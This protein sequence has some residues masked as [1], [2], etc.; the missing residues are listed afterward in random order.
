MNI[1]EYAVIGCAANLMTP[2]ELHV[3]RELAALADAGDKDAYAAVK[4]M[5][6]EILAN[7]NKK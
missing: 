3:A 2:G 7:G 4:H 5:V 1:W 6:Y